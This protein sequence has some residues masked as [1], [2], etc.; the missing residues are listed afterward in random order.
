MRRYIGSN[1]NATDFSQQA[2]LLKSGMF[3]QARMADLCYFRITDLTLEIKKDR[4]IRRNASVN[5]EENNK[6]EKQQI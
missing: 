4:C 3:R 6:N 5:K 2:C 1:Y